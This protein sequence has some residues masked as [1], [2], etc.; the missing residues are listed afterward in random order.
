MASIV[1]GQI[2]CFAF[3]ASVRVTLLAAAGAAALLIASCG[4]ESPAA[5]SPTA[6]AQ[7]DS[8]AGWPREIRLGLVPSEGG[9]DVVE[10]FRPLADHLSRTLNLPVS[11][12]SASSYSGVLIA[13]SNDQLELAYLGP[14]I[15][16]EAQRRANAQPL[17][18][19][20]NDEGEPFYH[21]VLVA[22]A[23]SP[24]RSLDDA[25]GKT[26]A[27]TDP[28]SLSGYLTPLVHM[29]RDGGF[30]P[31]D[32]FSRVVFSGSHG[33]S[34][35]SV[36]NGDIDVA[37]TNTLDLERIISRNI[38]SRDELRTIWTSE[39]L[40]GSVFV[41]RGELPET[42]KDALRRAMLDFNQ[43][44]AALEKMRFKGFAGVEDSDFDSV[45]LA[46]EQEKALRDP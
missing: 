2:R 12:I 38:V 17:V 5:S 46:M 36:K 26:L 33:A 22:A 23:A 45:R 19:E 9:T 16:V 30:R 21:S 8:R 6:P 14:K 28:N 15:Y 10:T 39:A 44:Q 40:P 3:Q 1:P 43:D 32:H 31:E 20:L 24:I 35:L 34:V 4:R 29:V 11:S 27:F 42:L 13:M 25:K 18:I 41:C 37:A 7:P